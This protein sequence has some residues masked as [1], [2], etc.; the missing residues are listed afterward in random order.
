MNAGQKILKLYPNNFEILNDLGSV[1]VEMK[2]FDKALNLYN[3]AYEINQNAQNKLQ[4]LR[5][6][7]ELYYKMKKYDEA[8]KFYR[9]LTELE[10]ENPKIWSNIAVIFRYLENHEDAINAFKKALELAP[11]RERMQEYGMK[12]LMYMKIKEKKKME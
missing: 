8:I 6:L 10:P 4:F 9:E 7:G 2:K 1:Y 11:E 3:K 12:W 5:N